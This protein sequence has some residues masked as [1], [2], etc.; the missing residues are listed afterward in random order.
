MMNEM[1]PPPLPPK[2]R[3]GNSCST[4]A[5]VGAGA[6]AVAVAGAGATVFVR[7]NV[8]VH[9]T[10]DSVTNAYTS[11]T[12]TS[13]TTVN[14]DH[15]GTGI[16]GHVV[17]IKINPENGELKTSPTPIITSVQLNSHKSKEET[18]GSPTSVV[19][20]SIGDNQQQQHHQSISPEEMRGGSDRTSAYFFCNGGISAVMSSGQCSPSDT[21]DSG[22]CSDLDGTPPP[23]P[24]KKSVTVTVIGAQHKR[25]SSLTSS[26]ADPD[27]ASGSDNESN[28]SCDSLNSNDLNNHEGIEIPTPPPLIRQN[29]KNT[30][31][32]AFLPQG[33]LKD[34]RDRSAKLSQPTINLTDVKETI[35][36]TIEIIEHRQSVIK[37]PEPSVLRTSPVFVSESTYEERQEQKKSAVVVHATEKS[38][39]VYTYETDKYYKFHLNEH[40]VDTENDTPASSKFTEEDESF[41]G[42]RD[43]LGGDGAS[44]IRSA[45]GTVRGVKNR[46]RAGIATF[47]QI[48]DATTKVRA[49]LI[50]IGSAKHRKKNFLV[51]NDFLQ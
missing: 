17:K 12:S 18:P 19:R 23:L 30:S 22:T 45:K 33:L 3:G 11:Y 31:S 27:S 25:A 40:A 9:S 37:S 49:F 46:V 21:L 26:G 7:P 13:S 38:N 39:R 35:C 32:S 20:I 43:L 36:N 28:I 6:G 51:K 14:G 5:V 44:T 41:A 1:I 10:R 4:T 2:T 47:L 24:K 34:I 8:Q 42:Y 50:Y 29:S 16:G 15:L 48:N